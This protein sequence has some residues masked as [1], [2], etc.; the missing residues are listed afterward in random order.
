MRNTPGKLMLFILIV[1][2]FSSCLFRPRPYVG[3]S[4]HH[5]GVRIHRYHHGN[6]IGGRTLL[7]KQY[8]TY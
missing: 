2:T 5:N 3:W 7:V 6:M 8:R 4:H 1:V